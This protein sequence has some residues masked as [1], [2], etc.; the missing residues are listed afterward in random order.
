MTALLALDTLETKYAGLVARKEALHVQVAE[1]KNK[2]AWGKRAVLLD[3]LREVEGDRRA[4]A[5]LLKE[6]RARHRGNAIVDDEYIATTAIDVTRDL[7]ESARIVAGYIGDVH[8]VLLDWR[9]NPPATVAEC[10]EQLADALG[11][12]NAE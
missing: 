12:Q 9:G 11:E 5:T 1:A 8:N 3:E 6:A 4:V 7:K 10:I 2:R